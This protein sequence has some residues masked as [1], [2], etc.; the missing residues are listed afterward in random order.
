[1]ACQSGCPSCCAGWHAAHRSGGSEETPRHASRSASS[2]RS[3]YRS[4]SRAPQPPQLKAL[5]C[6]RARPPRLP[7]GGVSALPTACALSARASAFRVRAAAL[8]VLT[9]ALPTACALTALASA[10]RVRASAL[11]ALTSTLPALACAFGPL[12]ASTLPAAVTALASALTTLCAEGC[13]AA[14]LP[15]ASLAPVGCAA[16]RHVGVMRG[17][18]AAADASSA[19]MVAAAGA[20]FADERGSAGGEGA[21]KGGQGGV[22]GGDGVRSLCQA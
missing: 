10:F 22:A 16:F 17:R 21:A 7:D 6:R 19:V 11:T 1:M 4:A 18:G 8:T 15:A 13:T 14:S 2:T 5:G 20:R 12:L 9:S 3:M